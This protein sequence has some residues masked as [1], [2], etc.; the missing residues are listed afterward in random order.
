[1]RSKMMAQGVGWLSIGVG[2]V[3]LV[4]PPRLGGLVGYVQK[5]ALVRLVGVRDLCIGAGLLRPGNGRR[6]LWARAA[7]DGLDTMI[8]AANLL[9]GSTSRGRAMVGMAAS[10]SSSL[11]ALLLARQQTQRHAL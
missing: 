11:F 8:I 6:W 3:A 4:I 7:S 2:L 1:M 5:P 9:R 10:L